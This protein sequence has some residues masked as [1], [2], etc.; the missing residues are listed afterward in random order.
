MIHR[1]AEGWSVALVAAAAGITPRTVAKWRDRH[2]D[3]GAAGLVDRS[4]RPHHSPTRLAAADEA[5]IVRL[6]RQRLS[7]P[8]IGRE[9]GRPVATVGVVL[10]RHQL[11]RLG[12]LD[13]KPEIVRYQRA[14][15]G[16]LI[17]RGQRPRSMPE[18]TAV[19]RRRRRDIKKLGTIHRQALPMHLSP[20]CGART[21]QGSPCRSPAVQDRKRCRMHGGAKGSGARAGNRNALKHGRYTRELVEFQRSVSE[22][23]R[24]SAE[25]LELITPT[26]PAAGVAASCI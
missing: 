6:R 3:E 24:E 15:P 11:G 22:L 10:R 18:G 4:S 2:A 14:R 21:R 5:E 16:E 1:L 25:K 20:R 9:L 26:L 13:P 17:H 12:A 8:A 23:L 19:D 7:G